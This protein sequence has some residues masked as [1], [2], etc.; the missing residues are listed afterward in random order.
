MLSSSLHYYESVASNDGSDA[1]AK[2]LESAAASIRRILAR[3]ESEVKGES[4][5]YIL[6]EAHH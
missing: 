1:R 2:E 5:H 4:S 3:I 6:P